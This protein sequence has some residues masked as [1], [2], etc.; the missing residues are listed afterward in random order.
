MKKLISLTAIALFAMVSCKNNENHNNDMHQ[1]GQHNDSIMH[2]DTHETIIDNETA[3]YS[4]PMHPEVKGAK[5]DQCPEC[6]M[7]LE[8]IST[9]T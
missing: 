9:T 3:M 2:D 1:D 7:D 8:V 4:C 5:G 6:G